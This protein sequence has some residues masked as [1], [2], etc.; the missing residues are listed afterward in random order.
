MS[1]TWDMRDENRRSGFDDALTIVN[2]VLE[3]NRMIADNES[4]TGFNWPQETRDK[5]KRS[6][7]AIQHVV[8]QLQQY[9]EEQFGSRKEYRAGA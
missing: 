6:A 9:R 4:L 8:D 2:G 7:E 5:A 3:G 1:G